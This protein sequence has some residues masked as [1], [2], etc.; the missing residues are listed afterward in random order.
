M[1]REQDEPG[2]SA[3]AAGE[4]VGGCPSCRANRGHVYED[5]PG[6]GY[7]LGELRL[8]GD[9]FGPAIILRRAGVE[10]AHFAGNCDDPGCCFER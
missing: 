8:T 9:D 6:V 5:C 3:G 7:E 2:G 10:Y 1:Q 4:G